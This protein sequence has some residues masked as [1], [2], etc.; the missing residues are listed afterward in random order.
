M[1]KNILIIEDTEVSRNVLKKII[2]ECEKSVRIYN[3]DNVA[4]AYRL[5]NEVSIDL[6]L[7]DI[8]LEPDKPRKMGGIEFVSH[9]RDTKQY[10]YTP[11][12]FITSLE[13]PKLHAY[14]ELHCYGYIEKPFD[15]RKVKELVTKALGMPTMEQRKEFVYFKKNGI[16]FAVRLA[17]IVYIDTS[18]KKVHIHCVDDELIVPYMS[19][20]SLLEKLGS[21]KFIRCSRSVVV[22]R[23]Y[24]KTVD[25]A[26]RYITF[27]KI[28]DVVDIGSTLKK[29]FMK[30]LEND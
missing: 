13:D 15:D 25:P 4:E 2:T 5:A 9:I 24:I 12:I 16:V 30:E 21:R 27:R 7:V 23:D 14:S 28:N 19:I 11:V 18:W 6:F 20:D 22:N 10:A 29:Q 8:I 3:A 1:T 26:S 17:E